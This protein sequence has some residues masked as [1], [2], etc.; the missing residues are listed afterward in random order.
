MIK[1][2]GM[3]SSLE[4]Q[5]RFSGTEDLYSFLKQH[6]FDGV[7]LMRVGT[8]DGGIITPERTVGFHLR[9]FTCWMDFWTGN[10]EGILENFGTHEHCMQ[11]YGSADRSVIADILRNDF[12]FAHE[13]GASYVVLHV[14]HV[15]L[16]ECLTYRFGYTDK[17]VI[18][19]TCELIN[20]VLSENSDYR[21]ELLLENLWWPGLTFTN[22]EMTKM[23][24]DGIRYKKT[25]LILDTGH[26]MSCNLDLTDEKDGIAYVHAMLDAHKELSG[27]IRAVHLHQSVS[28]AYVRGV[29]ND[30]ATGQRN[31]PAGDFFERFGE[32]YVHILNIDRHKPFTSSAVSALVD[33][34]APEYLVYEFITRGRD[35][36][37]QFIRTQDRALYGM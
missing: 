15:N 22:P 27:R 26:L 14:S 24:L 33:R 18:R 35:E 4:D 8:P 9:F 17:D 25:G 6:G 34:I 5:E 29:L 32:V 19:A 10:R 30:L 31:L 21:F 36:L 12:E 1:L 28:G 13:L 23:L 20:S 37:E 3:T 7:E 2:L 16:S 11:F